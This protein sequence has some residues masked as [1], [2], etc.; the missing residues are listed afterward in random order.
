MRA[1]VGVTG[2]V[3][4]GGAVSRAAADRLEAAVERYRRSIAADRGAGLLSWEDLGGGRE[5]MGERDLL[6]IFVVPALAP[7][8]E[9]VETFPEEDVEPEGTPARAPGSVVP[10]VMVPHEEADTV[11][12]DEARPWS[13]VLGGPGAGKSALAAW[14]QLRLCVPGE[15]PAGPVG[16]L[17]PVRLTLRN[18]EQRRRQMAGHEQDLFVLFEAELRP[19]GLRAEE[20]RALAEAG[21]IY[22]IFDG[23]DEV[24][25]PEARTWHA[26]MIAEMKNRHGGR[27][28]VTSRLAGSEHA[29]TILKA[30]GVQ[31]WRI[32]ALDEERIQVW[33]DRWYDR[34][35][36]ISP[37]AA[38][39][40]RRRLMYAR[41]SSTA[42]HELCQSPLLLTLM[43]G[44]S[45]ADDLPRRR[46]EIYARV[47]SHLADEWEAHKK[48]EEGGTLQIGFADKERFLRKLAW[49]MM[50][51]VPGG[52]GNVIAEAELEK[53]T[54]KFCEDQLDQAYVVATRTARSLIKNLQNRHGVLLWHGDEHYGLAH[55]ALL[56]YLAAE[57]LAEQ[58][59]RQG[60]AERLVLLLEDRW[61]DPRWEECLKLTVGLLANE[62]PSM[63]VKALQALLRAPSTAP[64]E[65]TDLKFVVF[66]IESIADVNDIAPINSFDNLL[67]DLFHYIANS[68][69]DTTTPSASMTM[70]RF[71]RHSPPMRADEA[72]L[73]AESMG[74]PDPGVS[75]AAVMDL[76]ARATREVRNRAFRVLVG[77]A[78]DDAPEPVRCD[79]ATFLRRRGDPTGSEVLA[80]LAVH[81][82][83]PMVRLDAARE[84]Q[85]EPTLLALS[86]SADDP[87]IRQRAEHLLALFHARRRLLQVGRLR[88]GIV[89]L[90]GQR[91]GII[92]ELSGGGTRFTYDPAWLARPDARPLGPSMPLRHAPYEDEGLLPFFENLLPE[93]WLLNIARR[94][95]G[96]A[97]NDPFGLLLATCG[98][99][100]GAV[101]VSPAPDDED[102][103]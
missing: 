85:H 19:D 9:I 2:G 97:P 88:R 16:E 53:F 26:R 31:T 37:E 13:L 47:V 23:L 21:R 14:V 99:C 51:E 15:A 34:M 62:S 80:E 59:R 95:L 41:A 66:A 6:G 24:V 22:W 3:Q 81:A 87:E 64:D 57:E 58:V 32:A 25:D 5:V 69:R 38:A 29:Q 18:L 44:L 101:E 79:I 94:K 60:S 96:V 39:R 82:S 10:E 20:I 102:A 93:G 35:R 55:R 90:S 4:P 12:F 84:I 1:P 98:D 76:A 83:S 91:V 33:I 42:V 7:V 72:A 43:A 77:W 89:S 52:S 61:D 73:L 11:L 45:R 46:R 28:L 67:G 8:R 68:R 78:R 100:I 71:P 50:S 92:E 103:A 36:R 70:K 30:H 48:I 74:S 86:E 56:D 17:V 75:S 54:V 49:T 27:G 63:A 65:T 40:R